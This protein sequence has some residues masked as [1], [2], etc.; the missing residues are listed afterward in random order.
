[1]IIG[2]G[3]DLLLNSRLKKLL[4]KS[5][6]S[7][8]KR[9]FT[10]KEIEI[11]KNI[12]SEKNLFSKSAIAHLAK[13][14]CAKEAFAK[15]IGTGIGRGINFVDIEIKNDNLGKPYIEILNDKN[16]FLQNLFDCK[17]FNIHLT[18]TD[19]NSI[20]SAVVIIEKIT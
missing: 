15:A 6:E 7:F 19:Q 1:M 5:K 17:K 2:I 3:I 12:F 13:R 8:L 11:Y 10:T 4:E 16:I 18:I 20:S 14:F 9:V